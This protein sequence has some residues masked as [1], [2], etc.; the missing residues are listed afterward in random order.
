MPPPPKSPI[1]GRMRQRT[2]AAEA[3]HA[4]INQAR[5][6][7]RCFVRPQTQLLGDAGPERVDQH[8]GLFD[9]LEDRLD[10][11]RILEVDGD[12]TPAAAHQIEFGATRHAEAGIGLAVDANDVGAQI[13]EQHRRERARSNT[14]QLDHL[15]TDQWARSLV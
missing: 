12:R 8:I 13:G 7:R 10:A 4:G 9:K 14:A 11:L 5:I 3:G 1:M 6:A 15:E 2:V